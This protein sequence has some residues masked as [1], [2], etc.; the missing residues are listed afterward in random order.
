MYTLEYGLY[1]I[2]SILL[3]GCL[4]AIYRHALQ[5]KCTARM[6]Q[7]FILASL[8]AT[9]ACTLLSVVKLKE[10]YAQE[11]HGSGKLNAPAPTVKKYFTLA[12]IHNDAP[13]LVVQPELPDHKLMNPEAKHHIVVNAQ[14][15]F[16]SFILSNM[17][18][19]LGSIYWGGM[20]IA[21]S[22][23]LA[24]IGYLLLLRRNLRPT[25]QRNGAT[26]YVTSRIRQPFSFGHNIFLPST[27][28]ATVRHH[29]LTHELAHVGHRHSLW[30]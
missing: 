25:R 23:F 18:S 20:A 5:L 22:Y 19:L 10:P 8:L 12:A 28:T 16:L 29:V 30:L 26:I 24:Q 11:E 14:Y 2:A 1:P 9:T 13:L 7:M 3:C 27:L 15:P 6:A 4:Y 21:L 17:H